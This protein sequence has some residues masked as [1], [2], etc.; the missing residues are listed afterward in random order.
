MICSFLLASKECLPVKSKQVSS[1]SDI[2]AYVSVAS[3]ASECDKILS[4][5]LDRRK[6]DRDEKGN[7]VEKA[8]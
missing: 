7:F 2:K 3:T 4:I 6:E 5:D 1:Q 8:L